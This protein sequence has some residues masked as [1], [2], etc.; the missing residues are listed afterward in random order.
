[1]SH[2][3]APVQ[4]KP[5]M[6]ST[7]AIFTFLIFVMLIVGALNFIQSMSHHTE[8]EH[9]EAMHNESASEHQSGHT[10]SAAEQAGQASH[11]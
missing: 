10:P 1:M 5:N 11:H 6:P 2:E 8:G 3:H 9:V 7:A 4:D